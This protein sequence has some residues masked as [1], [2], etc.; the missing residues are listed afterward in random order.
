MGSIREFQERDLPALYAIEQA[1]HP[2]PWSAQM[3]HESCVGE[4]YIGLV[5]IEEPDTVI[6]FCCARMVAGE[7]E[8]VN[9]AVSPSWRR[10]G[11]ASGLIRYLI[12]DSRNKQ[13]GRILLEVREKNSAALSLYKQAG[14]VA[15]G[16]R[17]EYYSNKDNAILMSLQLQERIR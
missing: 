17:R 4:G 10:K 5:S 13:V 2:D 3:L 7:I 8:I 14:F 9:L 12:T 11:I 16:I 1:S 15:D 6:G